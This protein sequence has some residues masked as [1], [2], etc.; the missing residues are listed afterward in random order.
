MCT[1]LLCSLKIC[2]P[3]KQHELVVQAVRHCQTTLLYKTIWQSGNAFRIPPGKQKGH[4]INSRVN[5]WVIRLL[6]VVGSSPT[7]LQGFLQL[8]DQESLVHQCL[9]LR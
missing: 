3:S 7:C 8:F 1:A 6:V 4:T 9:D 5:K 2:V